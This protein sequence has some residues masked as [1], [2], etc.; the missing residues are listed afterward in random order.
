MPYA[1]VP[2]DPVIETERLVLR[3]TVRADIDRLCDEI[4]DFEVS[5]MLAR[6]PYP[7]RRGDAEG[8]LAAVEGA[9]GRDLP[10]AIARDGRL[11]GGI[12]L[13]GIRSEREFG[14]WL[15]QA[16]WGAGYATEASRAFLAYVFDTFDPGVVRSGVFVGNPASLRVQ[17]KLGFERIGTRRVHCLARGQTLDHIDTLLTRDRFRA[18]NRE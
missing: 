2:P 14:Y 17:E 6:V 1:T 3:P 11:I 16:H 5:K 13:S 9:R 4:S 8:F 12:G 15:G 18:L 10:L 7:Y